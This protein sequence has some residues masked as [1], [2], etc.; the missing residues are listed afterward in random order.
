M[1]RGGTGVGRAAAGA[2][3]GLLGEGEAGGEALADGGEVKSDGVV[4]VGFCGAELGFG[5]LEFGGEAEGVTCAEGEEEQGCVAEGFVVLGG[6]STDVEE[7]GGVPLVDLAGEG[8]AAEGHADDG[9]VFGVGD[10]EFSGGVDVMGEV[11]EQGFVVGEEVA[12]GSRLE[13]GGPLASG[14]AWG[15]GG[16]GRGAV[17][18]ECFGDFGWGLGGS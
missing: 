10:F 18:G 14:E 7:V 17:H 15:L 6:A 3:G 2:L 11:F 16:L 4:E 13:E 12:W 9:V 1:G 5:E 8:E